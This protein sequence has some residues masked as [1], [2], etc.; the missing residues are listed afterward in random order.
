M[1]IE[2]LGRAIFEAALFGQRFQAARERLAGVADPL[3]LVELTASVAR[4]IYESESRELG[5]T[6]TSYTWDGLENG[7]NVR[8]RFPRQKARYLEGMLVAL[9]TFEELRALGETAGIIT[10]NQALFMP[11]RP[12][13]AGV[14]SI[15][16]GAG[17]PV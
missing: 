13:A 6:V 14:S 10:R 9:Q 15:E 3:K 7:T 12:R 5:P 1:P 4:A 17:A 8:Y 11:M 16:G 2:E